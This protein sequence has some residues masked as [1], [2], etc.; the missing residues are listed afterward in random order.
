MK[1]QILS[2]LMMSTMVLGAGQGVLADEVVIGGPTT[3]V[4]VEETVDSSGSDL[5]IGQ[6]EVV[7]PAVEPTPVVDSGT[8]IGEP[9][10]TVPVEGTSE[11]GSIVET[12][13]P[14]ELSVTLETEVVPVVNTGESAVTEVETLATPEKA[15]VEENKVESTPSVKET[16]ASDGGVISSAEGQSTATLSEQV[17][18]A[19]ANTGASQTGQ[20]Q[21]VTTPVIEAPIVTNTGAT[22]VGTENGQVLVQ[23]ESGKVEAKSAESIGAVKQSDGTVAIKDNTGKVHVLP[24]TGE[25]SSSIVVGVGIMTLLGAVAYAFRDKLKSKFKK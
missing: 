14:A 4:S 25:D 6:T 2:T 22:V 20:P 10:A 11:A 17:K 16:T 12:A 1:K 19:E 3:I 21:A 24:S 5:T 13:V 8:V 7:S 15:V 9:T 18:Q 23:T